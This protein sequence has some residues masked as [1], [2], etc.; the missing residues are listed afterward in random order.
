MIR[1]CDGNHAEIL[2]FLVRRID[3]C[4]TIQRAPAAYFDVDVKIIGLANVVFHE[5]SGSFRGSSSPILLRKRE[6]LA[7]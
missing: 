5:K 3:L 7:S 1:V 2:S 6:S 4:Q